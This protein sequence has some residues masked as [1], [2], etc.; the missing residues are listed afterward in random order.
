[1]S[2][3]QSS[4]TGSGDGGLSRG[5]S[6]NLSYNSNGPTRPGVLREASETLEEVSVLRQYQQKMSKMIGLNETSVRLIKR[7]FQVTSLRTC[8]FGV[9]VDLRAM[10][11]GGAG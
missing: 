4:G 9:Q 1:M 2:R 8:E 7:D 6:P 11:A 5:S 10:M 3:P